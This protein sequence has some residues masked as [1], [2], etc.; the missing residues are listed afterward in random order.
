VKLCR[1]S[2]PLLNIAPDRPLARAASMWCKLIVEIAV[3]PGAPAR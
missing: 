2:E 3:L 1:P